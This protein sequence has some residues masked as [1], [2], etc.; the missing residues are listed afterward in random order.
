MGLR[1]TSTIRG[2][3]VLLVI[4]S[5][6]M[7]QLIS[8]GAAVHHEL[9]RYAASKRDVLLSTAQ[10][11]AAAAAE[12]LRQNDRTAVHQAIRAI[13]RIPGVTYAGVVTLDGAVVTDVGATEVLESDLVLRGFDAP[14]AI[15]ALLGSRSI[16]VVAPVVSGGVE[17]GAL[18]L[19]ADTRDLPGKL[20]AAVAVS[21]GAFL[22]ALLLALLVALRLQAAITAPLTRLTEAMSTVRARHDY[23]VAIGEGGSGEVRV[24]LD[25]FN[26]MIGDIRE[27]D[28]LLAA[29]RAR[30]EDEVAE[31]TA[32]YRRAAGEAERA[33]EAKSEFLA[34]M[35]HE[36]RTPM[37]GI[38]VMAELLAGTDLPARARRQAE[39]I[40]R[41][42]EGLLAIINDI[43]DF[44]KI[45]AGKLEVE[46]LPVD[47][48]QAV[49]TVLRLF[50]DRASAKGLD[51]AA[52]IDLP[53]GA[54]IAA[55]PVRLGQ[56]LSNLVNNALKFTESGGV[57][58]HV[59]AEKGDPRQ[60]RFS[61][62]DTGIGIPR[63][64]LAAIFDAFSQ[65][66]QSTTRQYGGTGLG[67]SIARRLVAAMVGT[68][69]VASAVGEGSAFSFSLARQEGSAEGEWPVCPPGDDGEKPIALLALDGRQ[70][71]DAARFYLESAGFSVVEAEGAGPHPP[72]RFALVSGALG[73]RSGRL[74]T[75]PGG[76]V[77]AALRPDQDAEAPLRAGLADA[78]LT[79]PLARSD[80]AAILQRM[81]NGEP[82]H[83]EPSRP[84]PREQ[85]P[86]HAGLRV[87][88]V[89]DGAVNR[90]VALAALRKLG[91]EPDM[92]EDGRQAV[93]AV[94]DKLYDLV[95]MDGSMPVLDGFAATRLIRAMEAERAL[96]RTPIVALTA[97]VVGAAAEA[98]RE[99]GMDGILHK[100]FT[101]ARL[102]Q[103]LATH[104][105]AP[106]AT[107]SPGPAATP[108]PDAVGQ[109]DASAMRLDPGV[110][111]DLRAMAG[112]STDI[113]PR[114]IRL[115]KL[116]SAE[117]LEHL[118]KAA[119][120]G[121]ADAA[122][123][124]AHALKSMSLNMGARCMARLAAECEDAVRL[125][126]DRIGPETIEALLVEQVA[127]CA[128][129]DELAAAP[130][131]STRR[132]PGDAVP[133]ERAG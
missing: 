5:L 110:L 97:H 27:R 9:S 119:A 75:A 1:F 40:A 45:E 95:L 126:G 50:A 18:R 31:R 34:T 105:R 58:V 131:E 14:L 128:E 13:G 20:A 79:L 11:M 124:A 80:L 106:S 115:Y 129:L 82:L 4:A 24:L 60:V 51:L 88:V 57:C 104:A 109:A 49:D 33:N 86:D 26:A 41:S 112:G 94:A 29:H 46:R 67:L 70:S 23:T 3:L 89:D 39:V 113:L 87:L 48:A 36:I 103:C 96:P 107:S 25:G 111:A 12:G 81:R 37:N 76:V 101:L 116:Q 90:E 99:A 118:R 91:V 17:V 123:A 108:G 92:A 120:E 19:I 28:A 98:W 77:V 16:E 44:S 8:L 66:D 78:V 47:A 100:P 55:D 61:V 54:R 65:A 74:A 64:K 125:R 68:L 69:E 132:P 43:L 85:M 83:D 30:L 7:A 114:V 84:A 56:V 130:A 72:V 121:D 71:A 15:S 52:R 93:E 122:G 35:S 2:K 32:A 10:I 22:L 59:A 21:G 117:C 102:T 42:G 127:V 73:E 63:D 62:V 6:T 53:A 133:L 38:L